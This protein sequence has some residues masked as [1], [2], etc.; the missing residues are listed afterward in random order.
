MPLL[1]IINISKQFTGVLALS[2]VSFSIEEQEIV[3]LVGPNGAG[4]TTLFNIISGFYYPTS[5]NIIFKNEDVTNHNPAVLCQKGI[6]QTFQIVRPLPN[7]TVLENAVIGALNRSSSVKEAREKAE[8]ALEFLGLYDKKD[9]LA[10]DLN[11]PNRK[12]LEI[13]R[14]YSTEPTLLLLD[15]VMAGLT[16]AEQLEVCSIIDK[17]RNEGVTILFVEHNMKSVMS[18]S[19]RVV[20]LNYGKKI[21]DGTPLEISR[22]DQVIEA[23]LGRSID[24][25]TN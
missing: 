17:I 18:L 23:Y 19:D 25:V 14:A 6:S 7:L 11:L 2:N 22:N 24:N 4:K 21:A 9:Y 16:D 20:V 13:A 1:E 3:G 8:A 15:E 12:R 10:K 5:G